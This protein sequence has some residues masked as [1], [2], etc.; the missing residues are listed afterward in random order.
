[1]GVSTKN[2]DC[3]G[4]LNSARAL[5]QISDVLVF[6]LADT[7]KCGPKTDAN[8]MLRFF[9]AIFELRVIECELRR[10][11]GELRITIEPFQTMRWEKFLRIPIANL[12]CTT[13]AES[14][15]IE[16][17]DA[18]DTTLLG[19][20]SIPKLFAPMSDASDWTDPGDDNTSSAHAATLFAF[21]STYNFMQRNVLLAML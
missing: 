18:V 15:G 6:G 3:E 9:A 7:A 20:N 14:A 4:G 2:L 12:T 21:S 11:D 8:A 10:C 5:F 1:M 19:E 16:A 13:H 17:C